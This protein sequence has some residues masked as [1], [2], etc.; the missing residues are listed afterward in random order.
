M[1]DETLLPQVAFVPMPVEINS[2]EAVW[3]GTMLK[4]TPVEGTIT[5]AQATTELP[6]ATLVSVLVNLEGVKITF[7]VGGSDQPDGVVKESVIPA[8]T[9]VSADE[10]VTLDAN[11]GLTPFIQY[12]TVTAT[13]EE[14]MPRSLIL[15]VHLECC[16]KPGNS[17][18][19]DV[20]ALEDS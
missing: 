10:T 14:T 3:S 7:T 20:D 17:S 1:S 5:V 4:D 12:V 18:T 19:F 16:I 11:S 8:T 9:T 6:R 13:T 2:D 15:S